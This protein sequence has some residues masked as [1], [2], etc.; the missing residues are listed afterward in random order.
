MVYSAAVT[1]V[2]PT[3]NQAALLRVALETL[4]QTTYRD[5]VAVIVDDGSTEPIYDLVE[6]VRKKVSYPIEYERFARTGMS[7]VLVNRVFAMATTPYVAHM[8]T[9]LEFRDPEWL[10]AT[11]AC[12]SRFERAGII[13]VKHLF[14]DTGKLGHVGTE[15]RA[16]GS[17]HHIAEFEDDRPEYQVS[18][19]VEGVTGCGLFMPRSLWEEIGGFQLFFPHSW[20]DCEAC[21]QVQE[22]GWRVVC[23]REHP[24]WH[25]RSRSYGKP[26]HSFY[27]EN[28]MWIKLRHGELIEKLVAAREAGKR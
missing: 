23:Q 15:Y 1:L 11:L 18:A 14:P 22:R 12:F 6:A 28:S 25:W 13:G 4:D 10:G 17:W 24:I 9:D 19:Y 3:Y 7:A 2:F 26:T 20:E 16:D 5:F 8:N 21:L 27:Y